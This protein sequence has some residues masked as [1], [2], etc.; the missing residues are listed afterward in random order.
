MCAW[1]RWS[2]LSPLRE[3]ERGSRDADERLDGSGCVDGARDELGRIAVAPL[4]V[5]LVPV[6]D[7]RD[8]GVSYDWMRRPRE[9][10]VHGLGTAVPV[11]T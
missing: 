1:I 9:A 11:E 10:D 6:K 2:A 7:L 4:A 8:L 5:R 3:R